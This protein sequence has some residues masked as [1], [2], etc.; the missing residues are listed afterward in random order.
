MYKLFFSLALF[1][2]TVCQA[3]LSSQRLID[4]DSID[5]TMTQVMYRIPLNDLKIKRYSNGF[6]SAFTLKLCPQ[7]QTKTYNLAQPPSLLLN[8]KELKIEDLATTLLK[9]E[10]EQVQLGI[11]RTDGTISYL[12]L[13]GLDELS[14][15]NNEAGDAK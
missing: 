13:G 11:N 10:V 5:A 9:K 12:Y 15:N 8:S 1:V 6:P 7:C 2:S 3:D 4:P 14:I